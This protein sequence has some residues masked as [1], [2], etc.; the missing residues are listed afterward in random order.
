MNFDKDYYKILGVAKTASKEELKAAY[1]KLAKSYHPDAHPGDSSAEEKMKE[2]NEAWEVL[3]NDI[4]RFIYD[5]YREGEAKIKQE[6]KKQ[7]QD[8]TQGQT[9]TIPGKNKKYYQ[10]KT[11]TRQEHRVYVKGFMSVKYW[12]DQESGYNISV[13]KEVIYKINPVEAEAEITGSDIFSFPPPRHF[14]KAYSETEL[15]LSPLPQP[16]KCRIMIAGNEELYDLAIQDIR[17]VDPELSGITKHENRSFGIISGVFYGYV[18]K[19]EE[20]EVMQTV[21]ECSGETGRIE[22]KTEEGHE[23][24]RREYYHKDCSVYW[25]PWE[26][27]ITVNRTARTTTTGSFVETTGCL[28]WWWLPFLF[29]GF[30]IWPKFFGVLLLLGILLLVLSWGAEI[31]SYLLPLLATLFV[32]Y[33]V[34]SAFTAGKKSIPFTNRNKENTYDT[35]ITKRE[36][37]EEG[38]GKPG[39]DTLVSHFLR[40]KDYDNY[41]YAI[42]LTVSARAIREATMRHNNAEIPMYGNSLAPVYRQ[43]EFN[44]AGGL[45]RVFA[46]FDSLRRARRLGEKEFA[47]MLVSCIQSVPYYLVLDQ[48]CSAD[49]SNDEFITAYLSACTRECCIGD[50]RFGVRSP[51]EFLADLKG[52]CDTR[53]LL[54]FTLLKKF[55]YNVALLTSDYY[56]HAMVAVSFDNGEKINGLSMNINNR[57]Y[58]PWETTAAGFQAGQVPEANRNL[59]NWKIALLNETK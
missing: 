8:N 15:F 2:I 25:G 16:V 43:M 17:I 30:I 20:K 58:Y 46:A 1:R 50:T 53:A 21:T 33:A 40:W 29:L 37:K 55:N 12:A 59:S 27:I 24:Y 3:S 49:Y 41:P 32:A 44:D 22:K 42:T 18:L 10:R 52:D 5:E 11:V 28:Q 6:G 39:T 26:K 23:Y 48:S 35:V 13:L 34:W 7:Q 19:V 38:S 56:R 36:V 57:N 4:N 45:N 31:F 47:N 14:Q 51:L 9:G 54:I